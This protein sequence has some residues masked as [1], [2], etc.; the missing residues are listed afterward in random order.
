MRVIVIRE[1]SAILFGDFGQ[2]P[3]SVGD[4]IL[5]SPSVL[6]GVEPEGRVILTTIYLDADYALDQVFWQHAALL[7]DR[8]AASRFAAARYADP[9]QVVRLG[10]MAVDALAPDLDELELLSRGP[11]FEH[12]YRMQEL[13]SG[14]THMLAP[15]IRVA[16]V[17][18]A[19]TRRQRTHISPTM[20]RWRRFAPIR[21]E[22]RAAEALMR[23]S[24]AE[25]WPLS[26]LAEHAHLS[27]AQ[28]SRLFVQT[29]G[30]TPWAYLTMLRVEELAR[31]M[32]E[33]DLTTEAAIRRVG[34]ADR[35]HAAQ[36]F[37][38][39]VGV[40]PAQYRRHGPPSARQT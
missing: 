24:I 17:Q 18:I 8:L 19:T 21:A 12:F 22:V 39:Y 32:R 5:L 4:V 27:G 15:L 3:V 26:K 33:T 23:G 35:D 30:K 34:W 10:E 6:C 36:L 40:T 28:L 7:P 1:G 14:I 20:P 25:P 9:F 16:P 11:F 29:Y 31:L 2:T 37:R 38:R 13:W